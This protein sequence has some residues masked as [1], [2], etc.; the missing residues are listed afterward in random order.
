MCY[1][2][3]GQSR[4]T[5]EFM[6]DNLRY[7]LEIHIK[8]YYPAAGKILLLCDGGDSNACRQ[9]V[10]KEALCRLSKELEIEIAQAAVCL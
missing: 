1:L 5:A 8:Y 10:V 6:C 7:F 4:D 3:L 9:H 2:S